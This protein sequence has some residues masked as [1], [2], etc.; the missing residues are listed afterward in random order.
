MACNILGP[1]REGNGYW[2]KFMNEGAGIN[3]NGAGN[4]QK[5]DSKTGIKTKQFAHKNFFI[6]PLSAQIIIEV[7]E[8]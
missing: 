2:G 3:K 7:C 8:T 5:T 6:Y 4:M 1:Q